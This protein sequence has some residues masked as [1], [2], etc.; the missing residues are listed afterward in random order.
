M[1][2]SDVTSIVFIRRCDKSSSSCHERY[3]WTKPS[4]DDV[5]ISIQVQSS[6][7]VF[8]R[9]LRF[10]VL[11]LPSRPL[12]PLPPTSRSSVPSE[13]LSKRS[14][15]ACNTWPPSRK[16]SGKRFMMKRESI[17]VFRYLCARI[18]GNLRTGLPTGR[19]TCN[20]RATSAA[21]T[22]IQK[23]GDGDRLPQL[24]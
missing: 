14:A 2:F 6:A 10:P 21:T 3:Q 11:P 19:T 16:E 18:N 17:I 12:K 1:A 15:V 4:T 22:V 13:S 7:K 23:L 20:L 8:M 5:P 24:R 9:A